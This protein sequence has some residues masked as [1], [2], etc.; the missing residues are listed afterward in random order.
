MFKKLLSSKF[1]HVFGNGYRSFSSWCVDVLATSKTDANYNLESITNGRR[2]VPEPNVLGEFFTAIHEHVNKGEVVSISLNRS[3]NHDAQPGGPCINGTSSP[4]D[5][6]IHSIRIARPGQLTLTDV[7]VREIEVA[8]EYGG[9]ISLR[10]NNCNIAQLTIRQ[11]SLVTITNTNVGR[12]ILMEGAIKS[13]SMKGGCILDI[14]CP[15]P[16]KQSP[17]IGPVAFDTTVFLPRTRSGYLIRDVQAYKNMRGHLKKLE[18]QQSAA[19]F[20]SA[21]LALEREYDGRTNKFLSILYEWFSDFGSSTLRPVIWL[22]V[23]YVL[24]LAIIFASDATALPTNADQNYFGWQKSLVES[25]LGGRFTR[26]VYLAAQP[27]INPLGIF[28]IKILV[29]PSNGLLAL[30]L[31]FH[32]LLSVVLIALFVFAIRRR[33]RLS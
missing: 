26:A 23:L 21:E 27:V 25:G 1:P 11:P 8:T 15:I 5:S 6:Y 7:S 12:L 10:I 19:L 4:K 17:F 20:H 22:L 14:E 31:S 16:E 13:L 3:F 32:G 18:N 33:F 29:T 24:S 9:E 28:G 30:W 2:G